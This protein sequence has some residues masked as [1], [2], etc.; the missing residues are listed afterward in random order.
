VSRSR[1]GPVFTADSRRR[2]RL[3]ARLG[4]DVGARI[5][6]IDL[7]AVWNARIDLTAGWVNAFRDRIAS[8]RDD[9]NWTKHPVV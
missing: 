8:R 6:A 7:I 5:T 9:E 1:S 4:D 2:A 3:Q